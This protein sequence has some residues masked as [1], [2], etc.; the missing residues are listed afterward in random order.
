MQRHPVRR[1]ANGTNGAGHSNGVGLMRTGTEKYY[2]DLPEDGIAATPE[3]D[4][5]SLNKGATGAR[6]FRA[7]S[8]QEHALVQ[9]V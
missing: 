4:S 3:R 6:L 7:I 1:L 5:V 8:K 2:N 9:R